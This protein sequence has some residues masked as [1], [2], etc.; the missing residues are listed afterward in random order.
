MRMTMV[1][2]SVFRDMFTVVM[3][4][5]MPDPPEPANP[6]DCN[7]MDLGS[8]AETSFIQSSQQ[9]PLMDSMQFACKRKN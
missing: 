9:S 7:S 4:E 1:M 5:E 6:Y 8:S 2:L 3:D